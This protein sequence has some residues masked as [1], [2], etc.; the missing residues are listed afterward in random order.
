MILTILIIIKFIK[1]Y[2]KYRPFL[3][4]VQVQ[5]ELTKKCKSIVI[6]KYIYHNDTPKFLTSRR[7]LTMK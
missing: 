7:A 6:K 5:V 2:Q 1:P 3:V 4:Q